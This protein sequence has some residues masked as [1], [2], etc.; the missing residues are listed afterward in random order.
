VSRTYWRIAP[1]FWGDEK[2]SRWSDDAR[3][4]A[5]Y[6]LTCEHRTLEGLFRLPKGYVMA[7]LGWSAERL[8]EPF[9][10]LLAGGFIEYDETLRVCLIVNALAYQAPENPNQVTAALKLLEELPETALFARLYEQAQRLCQRLAEGLAQR[11]PERLGQPPALTPAPAPALTDIPAP[12]VAREALSV[13]N[14]GGGGADSDKTGN[15]KPDLDDPVLWELWALP[16]WQK[17]P[18]A[19]AALIAQIR[20][21]YPWVSLDAVFADY[22]LSA[23]DTKIGQ[24]RRFMLGRAK[25]LAE[26][27]GPEAPPDLVRPEMVT[28]LAAMLAEGGRPE[29]V[30]DMC[31]SEAEYQAVIGDSHAGKKAAS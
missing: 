21:E 6:L 9:G 3:F 15:S 27:A 19:D 22:R 5:L 29:E 20:S 24:P 14:S 18:K 7:D 8:A 25:T 23:G 17:Q 26:R 11:F 16:E 4:L 30:R 10:Q 2:V 12:P 28:S 31:A 1:A 13:D